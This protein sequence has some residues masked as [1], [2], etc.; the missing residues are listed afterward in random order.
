MKGKK[1]YFKLT[2]EDIR[3]KGAEAGK[4]TSV[5]LPAK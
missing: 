2:M 1:P 3:K 5:L 4:M